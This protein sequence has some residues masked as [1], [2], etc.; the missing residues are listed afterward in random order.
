[1]FKNNISIIGG[2]GHVGFPLGLAF[3]ESGMKVNLVDTN[4]QSNILINSGELPFKEDKAKKI[5]QKNLKKKKNF[6]HNQ[7]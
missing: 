1:M 2:A 7:Y 4:K 5:L 6:C 3:A